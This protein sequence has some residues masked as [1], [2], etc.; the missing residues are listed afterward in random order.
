MPTKSSFYRIFL[1]TVWQEKGRVPSEQ[2]V[3]RFRL[4]DPHTGWQ[5]VFADAASLL[6]VLQ[7]IAAAG[8]QAVKKEGDGED[9]AGLSPED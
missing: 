8:E 1:L 5:K 6:T 3:W 9:R 2:F 7:V 4:E